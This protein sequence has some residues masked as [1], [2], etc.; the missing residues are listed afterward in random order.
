M[1]AQESW[2]YLVFLL[3]IVAGLSQYFLLSFDFNPDSLIRSYLPF[4]MFMLVVGS[5]RLQLGLIPFFIACCATYALA[6]VVAE[7]GSLFFSGWLA[8]VLFPLS[9]ISNRTDL[10][11]GSLSSTI[12]SLPI[13]LSM[14]VFYVHS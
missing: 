4:L 8:L 1:S 9:L 5:I 2:R 10:V 11:V 3:Y 14:L 13:T 7:V 12:V 6:T